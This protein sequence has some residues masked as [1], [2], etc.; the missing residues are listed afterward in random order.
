M[1][2]HLTF[3]NLTVGEAQRV[4]VPVLK[5]ANIDEPVMETRMLLG[6][7]LGGGPERVLADRDNTLTSQQ[8]KLLSDIV[9]QR[10]HRVPMSHILGQREF[11]SMIFKV[12]GDTLT[13]RPDTETLVEAVLE[14]VSPP[15]KRILDL[16][17]G[18]GCIL[19][20]LLSE[21]GDAQ[22]VGVDV[23]DKALAVALDNAQSHKLDV[24]A[25]FVKNDWEQSEWTDVWSEPFDVVV[26]NPPYIP[27]ADIANLDVD[28][29]DYEPMSALVG[30][31]DG[32]DAYR[33]ITDGLN[34]LISPGGVVG[35]EVGIDQ[36][37]DVAGILERAG[38]RVL[39][40][41]ND[42]GGIPRAVI[43]CK[44]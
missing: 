13:P 22:G 6:F 16:G 43:G 37:G 31:D 30:G 21:W 11:W 9:G 7:V 17:T 24:R 4:C 15:P 34:S 12:T 5:A 42:L 18:T 23:S 27:Q 2:D 33:R 1:S 40:T 8:S 41:R 32:L 14:N 28:V 39:E 36:A 44:T 25:S 10:S 29:R 20:A 35:F 26:S 3:E 38:F 19:L